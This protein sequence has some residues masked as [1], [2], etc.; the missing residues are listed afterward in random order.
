MS[1]SLLERPAAESDEAIL[2][3]ARKNKRRSQIRVWGLRTLL[4]VVWLA[5][6]ELAATLWLDPF[7][8][9]KPSLIW[10]RLVEW[11]TIG[12][13]FGSIWL[14]I[15]TTVEEAVLGFLIGTVAGVTLGVLLGRSRYWSEVLAPF[16]KALNAVPR[17]VLASLFIIWFGLGLSSKVA[18]VVVLVFFAVFFNAFTGAREVDG[19]VINNARI[20]GASPTRILTSIVLPSATSWI[21]SSLHTAFGFALIGAVV[22][23][24]AGASKGLGLLISNAQGT[25]DSAGIYAGMIIITVVALL[26][27]WLIGIAESRLLKWRPSQSSSGHGV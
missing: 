12:T 15:F 24:Y 13:Q 20:L 14:Q 4:V 27:E 2:E 23:E 19:N 18:T 6:W 5:S 9:S 10:A 8:Y 1:H 11:F 7:F 25:F 16:I 17:I 21:L 26:A 22:G 3:R